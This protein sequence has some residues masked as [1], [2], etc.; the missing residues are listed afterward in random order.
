MLLGMHEQALAD[1]QERAAHPTRSR[2]QFLT[3]FPLFQPLR[4]DARFIALAEKEKQKLEENV[5]K[6]RDLM[7][8]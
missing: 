1:L 7:A 5:A 8:E 3:R 2:Y 6:Y 4:Q